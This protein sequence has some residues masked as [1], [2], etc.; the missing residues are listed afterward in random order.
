VAAFE[1]VFQAG[2]L[3]KNPE[4]LCRRAGPKIPLLRMADGEAGGDARVSH[5]WLLEA[6]TV[7]GI[8]VKTSLSRAAWPQ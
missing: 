5:A 2:A 6:G 8:A 3:F 7:L 4:T 1:G